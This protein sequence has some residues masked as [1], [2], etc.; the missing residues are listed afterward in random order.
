MRNVPESSDGH[1]PAV[2]GNPIITP[3]EG[4]AHTF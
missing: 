1:G 4:Q 2:L 3:E